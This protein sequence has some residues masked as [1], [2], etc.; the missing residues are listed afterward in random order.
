MHRFVAASL[1][2]TALVVS[3]VHAAEI[4]GTRFTSGAWNGAAYS[5]N[6]TGQFSH[7]VVNTWQPGDIR[8]LVS[9]DGDPG[10]YVFAL[11]SNRWALRE[12]EKYS[13]FVEIDN[14]WSGTAQ[15]EVYTSSAIR[16]STR[17]TSF[18]RAFERGN[19][20]IVRTPQTTFTLSLS[21]SARA[22]KGLLECVS[23]QTGQ[24]ASHGRLNPF[25][26]AQ[27]HNPFASSP[28]YDFQKTEVTNSPPR[29]FNR[30][31]L[32][33]ILHEA[34]LSDAYIVNPADMPTE[35]RNFGFVWVV[36][37]DVIGM[38]VE[39]RPA[40]AKSIDEVLPQFFGGM[41]CDGAWASGGKVADS[42]TARRGILTC[43]SQQA[44]K[45]YYVAA[46]AYDLGNAYQIY[47]HIEFGSARGED[48]TVVDDAFYA[49]LARRLH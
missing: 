14:L 49:A 22:L 32:Q 44:D 17:D 37:R 36:G 6:S 31:T 4:P 28:S 24:W 41:N 11:T 19:V 8:L 21:G 10:N 42:S 7:C 33:Q 30:N 34:R 47:L 48:A 39:F 43:Q 45:S 26:G 2:T 23:R 18:L 38:M 29:Y 27:H 1:V 20:L 9:A 40:V 5:D 3:T 15:I 12:G 13:V 46:T 25:L 35:M 16:F